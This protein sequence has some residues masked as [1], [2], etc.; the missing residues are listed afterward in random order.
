MTR[1]S[2]HITSRRRTG[3]IPPSTSSGYLGLG[4]FDNWLCFIPSVFLYFVIFFYWGICI[5][6]IIGKKILFLFLIVQ[7]VCLQ[8]REVFLCG[9]ILECRHQRGKAWLPSC[10][11]GGPP[12]PPGQPP[13]WGT[14]I[15]FLSCIC[16]ATWIP[17]QDRSPVRRSEVGPRS[18]ERRRK[19]K[20]HCLGDFWRAPG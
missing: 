4:T 17:P 14:G 2:R 19:I 18:W 6:Y 11:L 13:L 5:T 15:L 3:V 16:S 20:P 10:L 12:R 7:K 8:N 9:R 1:V